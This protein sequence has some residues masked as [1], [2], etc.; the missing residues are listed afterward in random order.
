[1]VQHR[2]SSLYADSHTE[3]PEVFVMIYQGNFDDVH[4]LTGG[5]NRI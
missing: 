3:T 4:E 1:M 2:M 5:R